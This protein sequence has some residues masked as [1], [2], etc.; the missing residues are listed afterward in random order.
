MWGNS[1]HL[2]S[3]PYYALDNEARLFAP[4]ITLVAADYIYICFLQLF[5]TTTGLM[6][7]ACCSQVVILYVQQ[8]TFAEN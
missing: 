4:E 7:Y 5:K 6:L 3:L 1:G 8:H 2:D